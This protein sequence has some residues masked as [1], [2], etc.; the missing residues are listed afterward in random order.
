MRTWPRRCEVVVRAEPAG[1]ADPA[2][3]AVRLHYT[4]C[5]G[6]TAVFIATAPTT[7]YGG[8]LENISL[9]FS[10]SGQLIRGESSSAHIPMDCTASYDNATLTLLRARNAEMEVA[11]GQVIG[12]VTTPMEAHTDAEVVTESESCTRL[13]I[14]GKATHV[15]G[16][17][18]AACPQGAFIADAMAHVAKS[19]L[20]LLNAGS[21]FTSLT[22]G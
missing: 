7:L 17:R 18:V 12:R 5:S 4:A 6:S 11:L 19:D 3:R 10:E 1:H 15:C 13:M 8:S 20:A 2:G 21:R 14:D 16:C 22:I 9:A